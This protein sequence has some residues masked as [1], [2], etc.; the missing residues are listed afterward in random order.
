MANR[1]LDGYVMQ[2]A[3]KLEIMV[4]HDGPAV[5]T[6]VGGAGNGE[7][8]NASD[9]GLGGFENIDCPMAS[10]DGLTSAIVSLVGQS[11]SAAIK[12]NAVTQA[13]IRYFVIATGSEV[14]NNTDLSAK[15]FRLQIRG[16]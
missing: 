11:T 4:D 15:S 2:L 1:F 9:F 7:L 16:V 3:D 6:Y 14:A 8:I 5:N 13:R 12:G 10:S